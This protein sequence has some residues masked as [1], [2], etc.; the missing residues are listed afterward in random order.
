VK[1]KK[2]PGSD[3]AIVNLARATTIPNESEKRVLTISA[4]HS[5]PSGKGLLFIT[6]QARTGGGRWVV[7]GASTVSREGQDGLLTLMLLTGEQD[8]ETVEC[9]W[10]FTASQ[11]DTQ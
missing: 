1:W 3:T 6:C 8:P 10:E 4:M 11:E 2:E 9:T 5:N 7:F